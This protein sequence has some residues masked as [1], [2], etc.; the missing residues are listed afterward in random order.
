MPF[1]TEMFRTIVNTYKLGIADVKLG[2]KENNKVMLY[3]GRRR[4]ASAALIHGGL[5]IAL[6]IFLKGLMGMD[7][8]KDEFFR[9]A[10][11]EYAK[12]TSFWY[13]TDF[14]NGEISTIDMT[15]SNLFS[16][17]LDVI[18][19]S[20]MAKDVTKIPEIAG[21]FVTQEFLGENIAAG[22]MI[23]V[24]RN[25]NQGTGLPI[26]LDTD[27]FTT[28]IVKASKH[29]VLG[30]YTPALFKKGYK[31]GQA[32]YRP[33]TVDGDTPLGIMAKTLLPTQLRTF[34]VDDL[35]ARG[36]RNDAAS[37]RQVWQNAMGLKS[38]YGIS[39]REA[40][41]QNQAVN[42]ARVIVF[43]K[44]GKRY[45]AA[46]SMGV[47]PAKFM[48]AA[49]DAS[50]SRAR[51][52]MAIRGYTDRVVMS[53]EDLREIR[54]RSPEQYEIITGIYRRTARFPLLE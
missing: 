48:A 18:T 53:S 38:K 39:E 26:W 10:M 54:A 43:S 7:D 20:M 51:V 34:K 45:K 21:R 30:A 15:Y 24:N 25:M 14:E 8:E 35:L 44:V 5:T 16:F 12:N 27:D 1:K 11:P 4:L 42:N 50:L 47:T 2:K 22:A 41:D 3:H 36:L 19:Q 40:E 9:D 23:D 13:F 49:K 52:E 37:N 28:K 32:F 29:L 17:P 46:L 6:P 31:A 33:E